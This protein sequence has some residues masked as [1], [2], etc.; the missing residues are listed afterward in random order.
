MYNPFSDLQ[1][2]LCTIFS[3]GCPR[4]YRVAGDVVGWRPLNKPEVSKLWLATRHLCVCL[5]PAGGAAAPGVPVPGRPRAGT[6]L[7]TA[8]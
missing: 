4:V 3:P 2:A 6:V 8:L 5:E 7:G 1:R